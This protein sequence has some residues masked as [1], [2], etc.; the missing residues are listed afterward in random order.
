MEWCWIYG[1]GP[2]R[3]RTTNPLSLRP[4]SARGAL[5]RWRLCGSWESG[6]F[7]A[8]FIGLV[9]VSSL[10]TNV[11]THV[12]PMPNKAMRTASPMD[13]CIV[14]SIGEQ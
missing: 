2:V 3:L 1:E 5:W 12:K 11:G 10:F 13:V 14:S 9:H 6:L 4:K 7:W 8:S